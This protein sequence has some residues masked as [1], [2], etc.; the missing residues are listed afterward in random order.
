MPWPPWKRHDDETKQRIKATRLAQEAAKPRAQRD[1]QNRKIS[2]SLKAT[3]ARQAEAK[4]DTK[5]D[6]KKR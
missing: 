1:E 6:G 5:A 3:K 2:E 4:K